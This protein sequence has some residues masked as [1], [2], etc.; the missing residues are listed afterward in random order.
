M[1]EMIGLN[2]ARRPKTAMDVAT[3][4]EQIAGRKRPSGVLPHGRARFASLRYNF[5]VQI[6]REL[7]L[8]IL[9]INELRSLK[10]ADGTPSAFT[11][12]PPHDNLITVTK[13][14]RNQNRSAPG[15]C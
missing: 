10:R 1:N 15:S 13:I 11:P 12:L 3:S 2:H 6:T 4:S 7:P 14:N 8:L 9:G 5:R